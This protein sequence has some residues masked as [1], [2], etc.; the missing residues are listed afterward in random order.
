MSEA[1]ED[2]L[3]PLSS[4]IFSIRCTC[5]L[6]S[7]VRAVRARVRSRQGSSYALV[8]TLRNDGLIGSLGRVGACGNC[9]MESFF[10]LLQKNVPDQQRWATRE[11]LRLND[12]H[13][14]GQR[15]THAVRCCETPYQRWWL[16][17]FPRPSADPCPS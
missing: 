8:R 14:P 2:S 1:T 11:E 9:P 3:I 6:R 12:D 7:R 15:G 17:D 13:S 5:R 16:K 10:A 4:K